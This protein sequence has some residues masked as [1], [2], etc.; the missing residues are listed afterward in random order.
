MFSDASVQYIQRKQPRASFLS[1]GPDFWRLLKSLTVKADVRA[2]H[3]VGAFYF[4]VNDVFKSM[5]A[6]RKELHHSRHR[7]SRCPHVA[8]DIQRMTH[9]D[10]VSN[11]NML[12]STLPR[13]PSDDCSRKEV[14]PERGELEGAMGF[15]E[16]PELAQASQIVTI[17]HMGQKFLV[18]YNDWRQCF[19]Q[20]CSL[21]VSMKSDVP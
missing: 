4:S 10:I 16:T 13:R 11:P 2:G 3:G 5:P 15:E 18:L 12:I 19:D 1:M 7:F 6:S 9:M 17:R 21:S 8:I 20:D 14:R